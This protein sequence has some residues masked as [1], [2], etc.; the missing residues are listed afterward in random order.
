MR[1]QGDPACRQNKTIG[2]CRNAAGRICVDVS[3]DT[4]REVLFSRQGETWDDRQNRLL[5]EVNHENINKSNII[6][7]LLLWS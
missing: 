3:A 4:R 6:Q 7:M 1:R 2:A 5:Y